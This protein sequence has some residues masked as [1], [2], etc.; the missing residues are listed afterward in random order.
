MGRSQKQSMVCAGLF[1]V[2]F[3]VLV[4][5]CH[6]KV[7]SLLDF[8]IIKTYSTTKIWIVESARSRRSDQCC[9]ARDC[10]DPTVS[11]LSASAPAGPQFAAG[12]VSVSGTSL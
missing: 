9:T 7:I 10:T 2:C 3:Y 8:G 4:G 12:S 1:D 6:T 5:E 11:Q